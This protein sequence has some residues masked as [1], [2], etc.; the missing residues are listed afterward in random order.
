MTN[1]KWCAELARSFGWG[2][3]P[4]ELVL[5]NL[6]TCPRFC[7]QT[8]VRRELL[9]DIS[10]IVVKLG[11]GVLTDSRK[12]PDLAQLEQLV[13]QVAAQRK[14]GNR[15]RYLRRGGRRHGRAGL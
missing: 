4:R 7:Y 6:D 14:E 12:Q 13:A 2:E 5:R 10:R 3:R 8:G 11:T 15:G 9:K 1:V